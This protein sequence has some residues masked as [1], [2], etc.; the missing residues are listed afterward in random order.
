MSTH[1]PLLASLP[2][3]KIY[4]IGAWGLRPSAY[5]ELEMVRSWRLFLDSPDRFLRHLFDDDGR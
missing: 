1:S 4:E 5:D 3:A 2:E